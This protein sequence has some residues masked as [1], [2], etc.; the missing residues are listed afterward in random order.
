MK[1]S[2]EATAIRARQRRHRATLSTVLLLLVGAI[3]ALPAGASATT[4]SEHSAPVGRQATV[5]DISCPTTTY[6][7]AIG[8]STDSG[9]TVSRMNAWNGTSWTE[10]G[11]T[12]QGRLTHISCSSTSN[13][14]AVG[15]E[16]GTGGA[17]AEVWN[18]SSWSMTTMPSSVAFEAELTGIQC[19]SATNCEAVGWYEAGSKVLAMQWNGSAWTLQTVPLPTNLGIK[20]AKNAQL[21]D[22]FCRSSTSCEAVGSV[23]VKRTTEFEKRSYKARYNGSTWSSEAGFEGVSLTDISCPTS[24]Y[25]VSIGQK[26][27]SGK[28]VAVY[29][30]FFVDEYVPLPTGGATATFE[31]V[32]CAGTSCTLVGKYS[33]EEVGKSKTLTDI[34][35]GAYWTVQSSPNPAGHQVNKLTGVSCASTTRCIAVGNAQLTPL[36]PLTEVWNGGSA[37]EIMSSPPVSSVPTL[38]K[39]SC[40]YGANVC[41]AIG[42]SADYKAFW[43]GSHWIDM[44]SSSHGTLNDVSCNGPASCVVAGTAAGGGTF[45]EVWNGT[46]WRFQPTP[47]PTG[48]SIVLTSVSCGGSCTAVGTYIASGKAKS[49]AI[50][51]GISGSWSLELL[52]APTGSDLEGKIT[53][54]DCHSVCMGVGSKLVKVGTV[55]RPRTYA[56][57]KSV[58][59]GWTIVSTAD[60]T[61]TETA[62][63]SVACSEK[64]IAVGKVDGVPM[65]ELWSESKGWALTA[66]PL[67]SGATTTEILDTHCVHVLSCFAVG[68]YSLTGSTTSIPLVEH[69]DGSAW[70]IEPAYDPP[71]TTYDQLSGVS[72]ADF[73]C[74]GVG[75][76]GTYGGGSVPLVEQRS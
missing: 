68:K 2:E 45:V 6:C 38:K 37:W 63:E 23:E 75:S 64:C 1:G 26:V 47:N 48:T 46:S 62:L 49:F 24:G 3:L 72:C 71:S 4:W 69:W 22:I 41:M 40:D 35:N 43:N 13:C 5:S 73:G 8:S 42:T 54:V 56:V 17:Y 28:P 44:G 61:G 34:W 66:L 31:D 53:D 76:A 32:S 65:S 50:S 70:S 12:A 15:Q 58:V 39:V 67:P 74:F 7:Q 16:L 33:T 21:N 60:P 30:D 36:E 19:N 25:C 27:K 18:G 11:T 51:G 57:K 55:Y 9:S 52:P 29:D 59:S 20:E 14:V 10:S